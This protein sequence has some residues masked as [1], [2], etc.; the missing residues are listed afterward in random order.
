MHSAKHPSWSAWV[1]GLVLCPLSLASTDAFAQETPA[2]LDRA[3][4]RLG[5][6]Y[7]NVDTDVR[8][9]DPSDFIS[10]KI[11]LEDD[12]GFDQHKSV[13]RIRANVLIG[14][15]QGLALDYY[16]LD[17]TSHQ[18]LSREVSYD[19]VT[20]AANADVNAKLDFDFGSIAWRWWFGQGNDVY[21]LGLGGGWYRVKTALV[22]E[23]SYDPGPGGARPVSV[24][25]GSND[26]AWAPLVELGWRHVFDEHWRMYLDASGVRKNGGR[27]SG[28]IYN[29]ALGV[30][31]LPWDNLGLGLEY[32]YSQI[33][34][35]WRRTAYNA[36]LDMTLSGPSAFVN[37]R[38]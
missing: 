13:P 30:E 32:G 7:A 24:T 14:D 17:R 9:A 19:G 26:S 25:T 21:G 27:I 31:W 8:M 29:A 12:L 35:H 15:R 22:G 5:G 18:T 37:L 1:A 3:S 6:Y 36:D 33:K 2:P 28:H 10:G 20:Y 38:W 16:S 34:L 11:N 4:L 23:G